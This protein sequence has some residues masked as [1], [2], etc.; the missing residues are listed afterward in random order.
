M[1]CAERRLLIASVNT[2]VPCIKIDLKSRQ[3]PSFGQRICHVFIYKR[4]RLCVCV[5]ILGDILR[6]SL[7]SSLWS[8]AAIA[9]DYSKGGG[10]NGGIHSLWWC[11]GEV[12]QQH[13][14]QH[15]G[16]CMKPKEEPH[17]LVSGER[18]F[19]DFHTF[20]LKSSDSEGRGLVK[21]DCQT[22]SVNNSQR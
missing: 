12:K 9:I 4:W 13:R 22:I 10:G 6:S 21:R 11:V 20:D 17:F 2:L 1:V 7:L 14:G 5:C 19:H 15:V 18:M 8:E 3:S 16:T